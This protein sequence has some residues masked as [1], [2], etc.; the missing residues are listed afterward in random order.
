MFYFDK[1]YRHTL[2]RYTF[3]GYTFRHWNLEGAAGEAGAQQDQ[4][5]GKI[6]NPV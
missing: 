5:L 6:K 4:D 3:G 2:C 1:L